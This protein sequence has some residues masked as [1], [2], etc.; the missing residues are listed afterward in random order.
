MKAL[1]ETRTRNGY[2][3][4]RYN[5]GHF[6]IESEQHAFSAIVFFPSNACVLNVG[7][8]PTIQQMDVLAEALRQAKKWHAESTKQVEV[9]SKLAQLN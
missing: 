2:Q 4:S 1:Y 9:E 5:F 8:R 3:L 7:N 6:H